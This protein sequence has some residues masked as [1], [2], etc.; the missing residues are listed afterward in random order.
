MTEKKDSKLIPSPSEEQLDIVNSVIDNKSIFVDAVAGSGK[1][2]TICHIGLNILNKN[3][4]VVTYNN[5]L[6][7][8]VREKVLK[9]KLNIEVHT[10]HSLGYKYYSESC[11]D[12]S[13]LEKILIKDLDL[14]YKKNF[15]II[16]ID[17][18]QDM[19]PSYFK[20]I[21]KFMNDNNFNK[22]IIT[23]G[24]KHQCIYGFKG[25][26]SRFLTL[27]HI[28][29]KN[30]S[31]H[32]F[33][34]KTLNESYRL[35]KQMAWF[36]ND[37][38]MNEK[39]IISNKEGPKVEYIVSNSFAAIN[40]IF[41][42]ILIL[43]KKGFKYDDIF[44]LSPSVK[45]YTNG[46]TTPLNKLENNLV[47]AN[48]PCFVPMD[49]NAKIDGDMVK[50]KIVFTTFHQSK[51]RERKIV[52]LFNF[53]N[54]YFKYYNKDDDP[55]VCPSI[56]YVAATR[57]SYKLYVLEDPSKER[58][59]FIK[60]N[61]TYDYMELSGNVNIKKNN[62]KIIVNKNN[63]YND[64][65]KIS[66]TEII[67]YLKQDI[68]NIINDKIK[69]IFIKINDENEEDTIPIPYKINTDDEKDLYEEVS[70][71]NILTILSIWEAK[72]TDNTQILTNLMKN[73]DTTEYGKYIEKINTNDLK[74]KDY[75]LIANIYNSIETKYMF[76]LAQIKKYNW[77][78]DEIIKLCIDRIEDKIDYKNDDIEIDGKLSIDGIG[79][80]PDTYFINN[81]YKKIEYIGNLYL[82][83][84]D[85]IW[86]LVC[87]DN[88]TFEHFLK[89]IVKYYVYNILINRKIANEKTFKILNIKTNELYKI[90]DTKMIEIEDIIKLL[91]ENKFGKNEILSNE[92][93]ISKYKII[94]DN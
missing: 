73:N 19:T 37:I 29:Y 28:I 90:D 40:K 49:N 84:N 17:E 34:N 6:K 59:K 20:L 79:G 68:I 39:R 58:F 86:E 81:E 24:D 9:M 36:V 62:K 32:E 63:Q 22:Q 46:G 35:T 94:K 89:I 78:N 47:N 65:I 27:S 88:T 30:I 21:I 38:M 56:L 10:Y 43:I 77:L 18:T 74:L 4:L 1:T 16:I 42:E 87:S 76:K 75:M 31:K 53:D 93:F 52:I 48:I 55:K 83:T 33:I 12:D 67:K 7:I 85:T 91:L 23:F 15:D 69:Q 54:S 41:E 26:D 25:A 61:K 72:Y 11:F 71:I 2:T 14:K 45:K 66:I 44:I 50:G 82:S 51:G 3:I 60:E 8:E 92:E 13:N 64:D 70:D 5:H 57:A 80:V